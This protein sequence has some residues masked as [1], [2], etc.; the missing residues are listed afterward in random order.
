MQFVKYRKICFF[1]SGLLVLASLFFLL[2]YGL[3][4]SIE[5]K[6]GSVLEVE[7]QN[8]RPS[9]N[10]IKEKL[11]VFGWPDYSVRQAGESGVIISVG[12]KNISQKLCDEVVQKLEELGEIKKDPQPGFEAISSVVGKELT[13]KTGLIVILSL[14]VII[15]YIAFAFRK[16]SG[17]ISSWQYGLAALVALIHDILIPLGFFSVLGK[18]Y[19]VQITIPVITA[20]LTV[21]GYSV[22]NT[23]VVFDR[24]RENLLKRTN[25]TFEET[26]N[27]SLNQTL[28]RSLNTSLTTL[29]VLV[30]IFFFGG[31][32]LKYFAMA[33]I[34]GIVFGT[35]FSIFLVSP[36]LVSWQQWRD[37][38]KD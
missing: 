16:I 26:V 24:I 2:I 18:L 33:L 20:L 15:F 35:Y 19:G 3:S 4:L 13:E 30:S 21:L 17:V 38:K 14:L 1:F 36:A 8:N 22:N 37:R 34:I 25:L 32:T 7:Y 12:E 29:F 23:V 10:L 31:E 27:E 6:G 28:T 9:N 11:S 5:F